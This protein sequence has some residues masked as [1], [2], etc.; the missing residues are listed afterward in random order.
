MATGNPSSDDDWVRLVSND[1]HSFLVRRRVAMVSGTLKSMLSTEGNFVEAAA[2]TCPVQERAIVVE[3]LC[4]Y[5]QYKSTYENVPPKEDIP[6]F[7]ERIPPEI[8]LEL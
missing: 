3:K 8:V 1:G 4:E 2:N 6:D 5:M 7:A